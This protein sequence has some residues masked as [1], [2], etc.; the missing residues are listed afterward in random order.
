MS[1]APY[2]V[3]LHYFQ[4]QSQKSCLWFPLQRQ[5]TFMSSITYGCSLDVFHS[6]QKVIEVGKRGRNK[7]DFLNVSL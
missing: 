3:L 6:R 2:H 5:V 4:A 1:F 7:P